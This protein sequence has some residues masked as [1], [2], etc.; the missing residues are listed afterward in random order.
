MQFLNQ[1]TGVLFGTEKYATD[2]NYPVVYGCINKVSR[3]HYEVEFELIHDQ[4]AGLPYGYITE[5][6]T[7]LLERDIRR[8]P[9]FWLWSHRRWKHQRPADVPL[10]SGDQFAPLS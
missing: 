6:H 1:E 3:G 10:H 8:K 5:A 7:R 9:E 4:P 2:Y